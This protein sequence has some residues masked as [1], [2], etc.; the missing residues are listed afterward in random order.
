MRRL[1]AGRRG[2]I[3]LLSATTMAVAFAGLYATPRH[4]GVAQ[5]DPQFLETR[6]LGQNVWLA[7]SRV[8]LRVVV[9]NHK[10]EKPVPAVVWLYL[11]PLDA[12]GKPDDSGALKLLSQ[13]TG[14]EGILDA[15][16]TVPRVAPGSYQL[17][18]KVDTPTADEEVRQAVTIVKKSRVLLVTDKPVYQPGQTIH[19]RSL[20]LSLPA[21]QPVAAATTIE[22]EDAKGNKVFKKVCNGS[23]FGVA[24]ADFTLAN[25]VNMGRY[26]VRARLDSGTAERKVD[27]KRYVLPKFKVTATTD[28]TYYL[29]GDKVTGKVQADYFFGKP[30]TGGAVT[31]K[32]STF[33]VGQQQ[34]AE[35]SGA[36]DETGLYRF[37]FDLPDYLVGQPLEQGKA[38]VLM[39]VTV[40]DKA[41]HEE[42]VSTSVPVAKDPIQLVVV[43]ESGNV[44]PGVENVIYLSASYPDGRPARC[45]LEVST[46]WYRTMHTLKTDELGIAEFK[47]K[48]GHRPG[49][50]TVRATD[51]RGRTAMVSRKLKLEGGPESLLLRTDKS[52]AGVGDE[53]TLTVLG[54]RD[55]TVYVDVI[56]D[57]QTVLTRSVEVKK[58]RGE[59]RLPLAADLSG[60]LEIHAYRILPSED[61]VRDTRLVYVNPANDL[62]IAVKPDRKTYRPGDSGRLDFTVTDR[63]KHPVLAAL[64]IAVVD[65]S[66]FALQEMQ[67]GLEKIYFTLEHEL[68]KPRYEVHGLIPVALVEG[69]L[70]WPVRPAPGQ[71]AVL[72]QE[73]GKVLFAAVEPMTELTLNV[74]SY[75]LKV[76]KHKQEWTKQV[77]KDAKRLQN[78][79]QRFAKQEGRYPTY[80]EGLEPLVRQKLI[81]RAD[82]LDPWQHPYRL[83]APGRAAIAAAPRPPRKRLGRRPARSTAELRF[84]ILSSAGPDGR[85]GT[86]DDLLHISAYSLMP[87]EKLRRFHGQ[88]EQATVAPEPLG[89]AALGGLGGGGA[90]V[91]LPEA[92]AVKMPVSDAASGGE[93]AGAPTRIRQFFPETM[94]WKPAVITDEKG[95]ASVE[96][97]MADSITTWRL[98]TMASSRTGSLGSVTAPLRVFQ[99]FFV[100][101]D[102][103]V[104]LT[105]NDEVSLPVALYNYLDGPQT[106][107]LELESGDW[108]EMPRAPDGTTPPRKVSVALQKGEVTV[109][110]FPMVVKK[111]GRHSLTVHA[112]GTKFSDAIRRE[113]EVLPDGQETYATL[114]GRLEGPVE[115]TVTIPPEA[116]DGASTILVRVYPGTFSQIVDGLDSMLRMPSGCFE[117]TSSITYPNVLVLNYMKRTKQL[118]P[119]IQMKAEGFINAGYQRLVT[120]EVPGG[121]FSWFGDPPAHKVLTAYGLM[122]FADMAKVHDVD[123]KLLRRTQQWLVKQQ[124]GDGTWDVDEGGIREGIIN[125]QTDVLR[126]SAYIAW[127]L[128]DSGFKGPQLARTAAYAAKNMGPVEDAYAMAVIANLL[129]SRDRSSAAAVA[130][131]DKLA[132]MAREEEKVAYW[133]TAGKTMTRARDDTA[134]LETTALATYALLKSRRHAG[135]TNKALT[136]LVRKK[137][138]FGTWQT[139]QATVWAFK[140]LLLAMETATSADTNAEITIDING[141]RAGGFA[142]TPENA[143]VMRQL[144]L[145][146]FVH[147]G[148]NTVK[149]GFSGK[150]SAL[151]QMVSRYSLPW[152]KRHRPE[153]PVLEIQIDYD[154][155]ELKTGDI[156]T[157]QATVKNLTNARADMVV[158]DLGVPPG[159]EVQA[160]DL[161]EVVGKKIKKFSLAARQIIVYL[162]KLDPG[163]TLELEYR[164][165][166]KFPVKAKTPRSTAYEYYNPGDKATADPV[167]MVVNQA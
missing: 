14:R 152:T 161:A 165:K 99:D 74:D 117:Q 63:K 6:V 26:T 150:G 59:V 54:S 43:P 137:D 86:V 21:R 4:E 25:E 10:T 151:Y 52:I 24:A 153:R 60:T 139:T 23:E 8:S 58:G 41:E 155:T 16:F 140:A 87:G 33:V 72:R 44:V 159:F 27:V 77:V 89:V 38:M 126:T 82:T 83:E 79:L 94:F 109:R 119:E 133:K 115:R 160:G 124:K 138:A 40:E 28:E 129:T 45:D 17:R 146:Q 100:D 70:P 162:D 167:E 22:V 122:E 96:L 132:E 125:R 18:V 91:G 19:I 114:T 158:L 37:E 154:K 103:P 95:R 113:I 36:T 164:L 67:P 1:I 55:G 105:Q 118:N 141:K 9:R 148:D 30:V 80:A 131:V 106:V 31:V 111:L 93:G 69:P 68:M 104:A 156:V 61:I 108:F 51:D 53:L 84:I 142:L 147:E 42:S 64:G 50:I 29:P 130:A 143:D 15:R 5:T 149:I 144:D 62:D 127:A 56:K 157:A 46:N 90:M 3:A 102:L 48:P 66:V 57:R 116:I 145:R 92:E 81:R 35:L 2:R 134:D 34:F 12:E 71:Q 88:L 112:R 166:A 107:T 135:L 20:A 49:T 101:L 121:G 7:G 163:E 11:L 136:Y 75:A 78:A 65:E 97:T 39:D 110:Y 47:V 120:F 98:T 76:Q 128:A 85:W 13:R 123:S 73:A 32:C